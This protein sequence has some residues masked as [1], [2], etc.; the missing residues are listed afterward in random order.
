VKRN[1]Y[2]FV[3][4]ALTAVLA[5][6]FAA[7][8]QQQDQDNGQSSGQTQ[9]QNQGGRRRGGMQRGRQHMAMIAEK[10]NLTD[11]Q[12]EQ[13]EKIGQQTRKQAIS[14]RQDNSLSD[15]QK[16]EKIQALRK[17]QH[18][19]M[20]GVLTDEQKQKLKELRQQH[21]KEQNKDKG[22]GDQASA[23]KPGA[24]SDDDDPFAGMTNDDDDGPNGSF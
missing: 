7:S 15:D 10:L 8:A 13:F 21:M 11:A 2:H 4:V 24:P 20:F 17:Q 1:L 18:Q 23:K 12:K 5:L 6:P 16:K 9:N 22:P 14:I 3:F 19:Q